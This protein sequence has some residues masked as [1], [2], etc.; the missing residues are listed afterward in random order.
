MVNAVIIII[1]SKFSGLNDF[2]WKLF[3]GTL[4]T[5]AILKGVGVGSDIVNPLSA[6]I[7]WVRHFKGKWTNFS[8][9]KINSNVYSNIRYLKMEPATSEKSSLPGGKGK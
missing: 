4:S 2:N 3:S 7:T 9:K 6:T 8:E 1:S 5:H